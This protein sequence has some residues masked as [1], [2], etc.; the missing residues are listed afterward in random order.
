M[1]L[2]KQSAPLKHPDLIQ[3]HWSVEVTHGS[4]HDLMGIRIDLLHG[5]NYNNPA[6]FRSAADL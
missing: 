6:V 2:P 4:I 1:R 5:A 3:P